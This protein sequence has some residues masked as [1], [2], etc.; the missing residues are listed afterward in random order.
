M[1]KYIIFD[2]EIINRNE[3][4]INALSASA[5]FGLSP[6]EGIRVYENIN[7]K[8]NIIEL[9]DH[10]SR[11]SKSCDQLSIECDIDRNRIVQDIGKLLKANNVKG[12]TAFRI[13]AFVQEEAS[14]QKANLRATVAIAGV[15]K[16][17]IDF[18]ERKIL[19]LQTTHKTERASAKSFPFQ[20]KVGANYLNS[21]YAH[22]EALDSNF[23]GAILCDAEEYI[24]ENGGA[25]VV[26]IKEQKL[27]APCSM[28]NILEGITLNLLSQIAENIGLSVVRS[29]IHRS[30]LMDYDEA[31]ICG[32]AVEIHPIY[33]N[34]K[35][36]NHNVSRELFA[37]YFKNLR[38]KSNIVRKTTI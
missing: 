20:V 24:T 36:T 29:K 30:F 28:V 34:N 11:L 23:D 2:G 31:F 15:D 7:G 9:D 21:R 16:K 8:F 13:I 1:H 33:I 3:F 12:D 10:L 35:I 38:D 14:W 19:N 5:Q 25:N 37:E 4:T 27:F 26:I 6:F 17:Y 18:D 32:S 22:L